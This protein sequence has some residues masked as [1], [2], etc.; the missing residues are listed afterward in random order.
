MDKLTGDRMS[1]T[2]TKINKGG[3]RKYTY[4]DYLN[5]PDDGN[6]YEIIN[7]DL[8]MTASP[9]TSHQKISIFLSTEIQVY[10]T[11]EN[12][13]FVFYSPYDVIFDD[14]NIYQPDILFISKENKNIITEE[15]IKGSPDLIVE[16]LSPS[17]AYYDLFEKKEV[18]EKFG[19]KEY[20][21]VDPQKHWIEIYTLKQNKYVLFN[22]TEKKGKVKS[23]LF[24]KLDIDASKLF[25]E[26]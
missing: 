25:A 14:K 20:W 9:V 5:L 1:L 18:Y 13:G 6:R 2:K 17:T 21:I 8:I 4:E 19:V 15:N 11:K 12:I 26:L 24:K 3:K 16:I 22:R 23:S 7:G 10:V